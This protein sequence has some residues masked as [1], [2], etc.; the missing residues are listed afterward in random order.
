MIENH[1]TELAL[2]ASIAAFRKF[3]HNEK[4]THFVEEKYFLSSL[5]P[6]TLNEHEEQLFC[7]VCYEK[8]FNPAEFTVEN[9]G[10]VIT[11][12]DIERYLSYPTT[13]TTRVKKEIRKT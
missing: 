8:I 7:N 12:E 6:R 2:N 10:G 9:Y 13:P 11:P 4:S 5:N 3:F 1:F